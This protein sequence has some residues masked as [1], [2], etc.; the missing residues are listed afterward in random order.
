ML[1]ITKNV[2]IRLLPYYFIGVII[3]SL[4]PLLRNEY[5]LHI[6]ILI[7]IYMILA[8]SLDILVRYTG[9]LNLGHATFFSP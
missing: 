6:M 7:Y 4:V 1:G 9:A 2:L 8:S 5:C 3:L